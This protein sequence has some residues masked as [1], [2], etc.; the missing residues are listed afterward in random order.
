MLMDKSRP[1]SWIHKRWLPAT[2]PTLD[3]MLWKVYLA[4][5]EI[6]LEHFTIDTLKANVLTDHWNILPL[7]IHVTLSHYVKGTILDVIVYIIEK[8]LLLFDYPDYL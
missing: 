7:N 5:L 1:L 4:L 8:C 2:C 3:N 6:W